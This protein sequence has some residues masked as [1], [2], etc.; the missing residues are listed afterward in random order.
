MEITI[1]QL[2]RVDLV[3]VSGRIDSA[4]ALEMERALKSIVDAG[5]Y[6]ICIDLKNLEYICSGGLRALVTS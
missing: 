4:A 2:K 1:K 6:R 5:Q 3:T